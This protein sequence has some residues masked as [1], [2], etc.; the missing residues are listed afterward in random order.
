MGIKRKRAII[1]LVTILLLAGHLLGNI[2]A[3]G[4]LLIPT[5]GGIKE[6]KALIFLNRLEMLIECGEEIFKLF[7]DFKAPKSRKMKA[8]TAEI[9]E[10]LI[11]ENEIIII[12]NDSFCQKYR[13]LLH[14]VRFIL[15]LFHTREG[16]ALIF[17]MDNTADIGFLGNELIKIINNGS[18]E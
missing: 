8:D 4:K 16:W 2:K 15:S 6:Y 17:K 1:T 10:I 12:P 13:Y 5:A 9:V 7:N 11:Q 3:T 14:R 18:R